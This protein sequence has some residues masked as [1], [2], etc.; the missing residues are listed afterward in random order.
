[1]NVYQAVIFANF[2]RQ[3]AVRIDNTVNNG[4]DKLMKPQLGPTVLFFVLHLLVYYRVK[5]NLLKR[6]K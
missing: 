4:L 2:M 6:S 5:R 1:M 3:F